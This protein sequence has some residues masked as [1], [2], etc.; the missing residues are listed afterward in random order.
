MI[1]QSF[2]KFK[3]VFYL[4]KSTFEFLDD[5]LVYLNVPKRKTLQEFLANAKEIYSDKYDYSEV[6]YIN[7]SIK[8]KI[9]CPVHGAFFKTP[10]KF[11][12]KKQDC[13]ECKGYRLWSFERFVYEAN[14]FHEGKYKYPKQKWI[15]TK[16][17][18]II[19]CPIHGEFHQIAYGHLRGGCNKCAYDLKNHK[20][21]DTNENFI[22]KAKKIFGIKYDYSN[23]EYY[24]S[25]TKI[26]IYCKLHGY[27]HMKP[28]SHISGQGCPK[29]GR[30]EANINI[31]KSWSEVLVR[32]K[33]IHGNKYKYKEETYVD[34]TTKMTMICSIHGD[35]EKKPH[36]HYSMKS[37]CKACGIITTSEKNTLS[38]DTN[39]LEFKNVHGNKYTYYPSTYKGVE[40]KMKINCDKHGDFFQQVSTHKGGGGCRECAYELNGENSRKTKGEFIQESILVHGEKY[41]YDKVKWN[42]Q[43]DN[44]IIICPKHG[45]FIQIAINHSRGS[46][47][48]ICN[49]SHGEREIRMYLNKVNVK[50][51]SQKT[52]TDLKD[53]NLLR[54]DF[55]LPKE[56]MVIEYNGK[57]HYQADEFFGGSD[58]F[59]KRIKLDK[60][61]LEYCISNKIRFEIIRYDE[62]VIDRLIEILAI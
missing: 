40:K 61:K 28:N 2:S 13:K 19:I 42:D 18:Y 44:V 25:Q 45:D 7:T 38:W 54:C 14:L 31:R 5:L 56:N 12:N 43:H 62:D 34:Y 57:Q 41:N 6:E 36:T 48:Q 16:S 58:A 37:G 3:N 60:I 11:L 33:K 46:G 15:N 30:I 52:F 9:I 17:K 53:K 26:K 50:F 47:C 21:R 29:C 4:R 51:I 59:E 27:F 22:T 35:F 1:N 8:V 20:Q 23:I 55:Y 32:F 49:E 39:L 10:Q 24:N